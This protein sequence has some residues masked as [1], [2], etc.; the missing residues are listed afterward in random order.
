MGVELTLLQKSVFQVKHPASMAYKRITAGGLR[1]SVYLAFAGGDFVVKSALWAVS[2]GCCT[3]VHTKPGS[4]HQVAP[5]RRARRRRKDLRAGDR[6][7]R[8]PRCLVRNMLGIRFPLPPSPRQ[9][10]A[11]ATPKLSGRGM[12]W[13]SW[14]QHPSRATSFEASLVGRGQ[15]LKARCIPCDQRSNRISQP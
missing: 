2:I 14:S 5:P 7:D 3:G 4:G 6:L 11:C 1:H 10:Y 15:G 12:V 9:V 13:L 8:C